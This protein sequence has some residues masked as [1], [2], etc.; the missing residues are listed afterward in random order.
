MTLSQSSLHQL[1]GEL[2]NLT[3][4]GSPTPE[5][6]RLRIV[7][8]VILQEGKSNE[9]K[10]RHSLNSMGST[11]KPNSGKNFE[12]LSKIL[13]GENI[14]DIVERFVVQNP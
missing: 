1:Q 8:K 9:A 13:R 5:H 4:T 3:C 6:E 12:T 7:L 2:S 14:T 10:M 11:M